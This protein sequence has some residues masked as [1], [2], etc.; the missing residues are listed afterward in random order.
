MPERSRGYEV[1][2]L[3]AGCAGAAAAYALARRRIATVVVD[4]SRADRTPLVPATVAVQGGTDPDVRLALRSAERFPEL[5]DAV[6]SFG[7]RRTGGMT[8]AVSDADAEAGRSRAAQAE[9]AGLPVRWLSAEETRRREP[10]VT[11]RAAGSVYCAYDGVADWSGLA[12]RL[13]AAAVRFGAAAYLDCGFLGITRESAGFRIRAG[14]DEV[15]ARQVVVASPE[16]L[17]ATGRTLG[18]VLP[19]R[20]GRRRFCVTGAMPPLLRHTI[21]GMHQRPSGE[22]ILDPPRFVEETASADDV[23]V[24][25]EALRRIATAAVRVVP[26]LTPARI[27]HTPLAVSTD[28]ADGRPAVGR[29]EDQLLLALAGP[30][31][32]ALHCPLI[33]EAVADA[34]ARGRWPEGL[35]IWDPRRLLP[36]G[37]GSAG[38]PLPQDA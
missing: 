23:R 4:V 13:L 17:H 5:Q 19:L 31:Q 33:G 1:A 2:V 38:L 35:E 24:L 28:P 36:A 14:R 34:V 18:V 11:D 21:N 37:V 29:V 3:G 22:I 8:V 26:G 25:I 32:G 12:R 9:A 7:Y 10:A 16:A 30:E 6:G 20:T 27:L 15:V